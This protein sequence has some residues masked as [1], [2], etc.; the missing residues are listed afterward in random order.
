MRG[1]IMA[2]WTI[3]FLGVRPLASLLDGTLASV[4]GVRVA[5]AAMSVPAVLVAVLLFS[6]N[7]DSGQDR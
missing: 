1:R 7:R 5:A 6:T 3:T 4:A 2:L